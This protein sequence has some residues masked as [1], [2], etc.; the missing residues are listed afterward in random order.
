MLASI[1][2]FV[3]ELLHGRLHDS[4]RIRIVTAIGLALLSVIVG[5]VTLPSDLSPARP[6]EN[7]AI[8]MQQV[9]VTAAPAGNAASQPTSLQPVTMN[10]APARNAVSQPPVLLPSKPATAAKNKPHSE[11]TIGERERSLPEVAAAAEDALTILHSQVHTVRGSLRGRQTEP[12]AALHGII[13]TDLTLDVKIIDPE[14]VVRNAFIVTSR[15][16]GFTA[17]ES[18]L[19][20]RERLRDALQ[21]RMKEP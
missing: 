19:Q 16:G 9:T 11:I 6:A 13:T 12:D 3:A 10:A 7:P 4:R 18:G 1:I 14:G 2:T 8:T 21:K 15:G 17:D 5:L 20:A